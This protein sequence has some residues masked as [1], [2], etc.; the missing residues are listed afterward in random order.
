V[1]LR[2]TAGSRPGLT[3]LEVLVALAIFL[4]SLAAITRLVT[5][6]GQRALDARRSDEAGRLARSKLAEVFAGAVPLQGAEDNSFD[7]DPDYTWSLT[8]DSGSLSG[9]WVVTVTVKRKGDDWAGFTLQQFLPDPSLRG[10]TQDTVTITGAANASSTSSGSGDSSPSQGNSATPTQGGSAAA[11]PPAPAPAG[12]KSA[13]G[14]GSAPG[15][16]SAT[17]PGAGPGST[18]SSNQSSSSKR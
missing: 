2:G 12:A 5:F 15:K 7:E 10:S 11:P 8:A 16:G 13:T 14:T 9:L 3:L 18:Q 6:A 1:S 4:L 17:G